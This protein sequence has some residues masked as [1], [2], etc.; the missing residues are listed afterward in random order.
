M[1]YIPTWLRFL[2]AAC[3]LGPRPVLLAAWDRAPPARALARRALADRAVPAGPFWPEAL[4]PAPALPPDHR[5]AVLARAAALGPMDWHGP[6][7]AEAPA[8]GLNLF[9]PGDVRPVWERNRWAELVLLAQAQRL[10]PG[11]GHGARA[12]AM[13][14]DWAARNPPFRGPNWASGQEAA[15]RVLHLALALDRAVLPAGARALVGLHGR[16]IAATPAYAMAQDNNHAISEPAG[17]LACGLLLG[18]GDWVALGADRLAVTEWLRRRHGLPP[19][20]P[21]PAPVLW[22]QRLVAA[23]TGEA[24]RLGHQDGSAFADLS[25]AGPADARP[26]VERAARMLAGR[27]AGYGDDLGCAWLGLAAGPVLEPLP[28]EWVAEGLRGWHSGA[29]RAVLRTGPLRFRPAHADLLHLDLWDGPRNLL[30]DGGTGSYNPWQ[31]ALWATAGHNT[32]E[33]DG[34][35][36]MPSLSRFLHSHWPR[37]GM[38]PE[39][40]WLQ[41][42]RGNR[43]E[44][45]VRL[46]ERLCRVEDRLAGPWRQ[47]ALRWRL[48]PGTWRLTADGVEGP[49][50]RLRLAADAPLA[51]ALEAGVESPAYGVIQPVP[52]LVARLAAPARWVETVITVPTQQ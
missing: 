45:R 48:A 21:D 52:V 1:E 10:E 4:P 38:L 46:E 36:Q 27:S 11:G 40:G 13:L 9:D 39:G 14:A 8:L 18:E 35:D 6:F 31:R 23:E 33:F 2:D 22:L 7:A 26:S 42:H 24:P 49:L 20:P 25:L 51:L 32:V 15:L 29:L 12:G 43:Q 47:A 5:Q 50:A 30:R 44:R 16:R 17:L 19:A 28:A 34:R 41:D 37:C 3:Q